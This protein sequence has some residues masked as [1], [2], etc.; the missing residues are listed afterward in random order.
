[1]SRGSSRS[2]FVGNIPYEATEEQLREVFSQVGDVVH[3][4]LMFDKDTGK[5]KGFGFCEYKDSATAESAMRNLNGHEF[6]G[7]QLRV[8]VASEKDSRGGGG[9]GGGAKSGPPG[10]SGAP[11]GKGMGMGGPAPARAAPPPE[12]A[13]ESVKHTMDNMPPQQ[14]YEIMKSLKTLVQQQPNQARSLLTTN[15]ALCYAVLQAQLRL[16]I[17]DPDLAEQLIKDSSAPSTAAAAVGADRRPASAASAARPGQPATRGF[18]E[19]IRRPPQPDFPPPQTGFGGPPPP[20]GGQA[21][22]F[23]GGMPPQGNMGM[24]PQGGMPPP[25]G[26]GVGGTG[27][28]HSGVP[29]AMP[30][31]GGGGGGSANDEQAELIRRVMAL[32]PDEIAKLPPAQATTLM[33]LKRRIEQGAA[34]GLR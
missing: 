27:P 8:D 28:Q 6:G 1:M 7:R 26:F 20:G 25:P 16:N 17:I 23:A 5:P 34:G 13:T 29:M 30:M 3:F 14:L 19:E 32:T 33:E 22:P 2:V 4:R 31:P 9:G 11:M 12:H 15:P 18:M 24:P 21:P 10:P